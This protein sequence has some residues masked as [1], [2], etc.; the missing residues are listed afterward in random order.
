M[1]SEAERCA[2]D[3]ILRVMTLE[4]FGQNLGAQEFLPDSRLLN[5][6]PE[7]GQAYIEGTRLLER[8]DWEGDPSRQLG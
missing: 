2:R 5:P 8:D 3:R 6:D 4:V 1:M 7:A